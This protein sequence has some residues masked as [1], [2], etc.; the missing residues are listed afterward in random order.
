MNLDSKQIRVQVNTDK[1]TS[2][3]DVLTGRTPAMWRGNDIDV[4][5]GLFRNGALITDIDA[6]DSITVSIRAASKT[7]AILATKTIAYADINRACSASQWTAGTAQHAVASFLNTE[8]RFTLTAD[9]TSFWMVVTALTG[10]GKELTL[11]GTVLSVWQDGAG[12]D[13]TSPVVGANLIPG[14]AVY[15]GGGT[16]TFSGATVGK[17]YRWTKGVNDTNIVDTPN[18]YTI[19]NTIF[20]ALNTSFTLNGTPGAAVTAELRWPD[21][22][23][24]D[25]SD[26]RY[27]LA[28]DEAGLTALI[29]AAQADATQALADAVEARTEYFEAA[30]QAAMLLLAADKGDFA[31]RT[32]QNRFWLLSTSDPTVLANWKQLPIGMDWQGAWSSVTTYAV[33]DAVSKSGSSYISIQG[34]NLNHDPA[35]P[36]TIGVWWDVLAAGSTVQLAVAPDAVPTEIIA[37]AASAIG[38]HA[39]AARED[40]EHKA[41][42]ATQ[43]VT[44]LHAF[45]D[46]L[47]FDRTLGPYA[48]AFNAAVS[49]VY[50][51][52]DRIVVTGAFTRYGNCPAP[53]IMILDLHGFP[54]P[55]FAPGA[56]F[57]SGNTITFIAKASDG[58]YIL[59]NNAKT[60]YQAAGLA[61]IHKLDVTGT[62]DGAFTSPATMAVSGTDEL[63][64]IAT[65]TGKIW[66]VTWH[67][68]RVMDLTG[69]TT[70]TGTSDDNC[71][72]LT[73]KPGTA[74]AMLATRAATTFNGFA[75]PGALTLL[76]NTLARNGDWVTGASAGG[77][78]GA[79]VILWSPTGDFVIAGN[80]GAAGI[81]T[82]A[83][84]GGAANKHKGLWK[85]G[86][87]G[88]E[89][90][91]WTSTIVMTG[92]TANPQPMAIDSQNRVYF[93]GN[94]T[95]IDGTA[96]TANR[97]YRLN[98]DG[99]YDRQFAGFNGTVLRMSLVDDEHLVV[100]GSF[101]QY[102]QAEVG[103]M[104]F[105][106]S[107]GNL[108]P[109]LREDSTG[110]QA[111]SITGAGTQRITPKHQGILSLKVTVTDT[112]GGGG[113]TGTLILPAAGA[114]EGDRVRALFT[115]PA[116]TDPDI[117]IK[118]PDAAGSEVLGFNSKI[119]VSQ[120]E[121]DIVFKSG[122]WVAETPRWTLADGTPALNSYTR[123]TVTYAATVN[124][125]LDQ[126]AYQQITATGALTLG[127]LS[128]SRAGSGVAKTVTVLVTA[129]G[130]DRVIAFASGVK[131]IGDTLPS[132]KTAAVCLVST[133]SNE[134]DTLA[135][136]AQLD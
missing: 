57:A 10:T 84:E 112:Y 91:A 80:G 15:S 22:Y 7:G 11:G 106:D 31:K 97:L 100:C 81:G 75:V 58:D 94:V 102:G 35:D 85:I 69:T 12:S 98:A 23:T 66:C 89:D 30:S 127:T 126:Q 118:S 16:Y 67:S 111:I 17:V 4:Q 78:T 73:T 70:A 54:M 65:T 26:A 21:Y 79:N 71:H 83:W 38:V 20:T 56:G 74:L 64:S 29:S 88:N 113:F 50:L 28:F 133:G 101:T 72:W 99:S 41:L 122:V 59:G 120:M 103:G 8:T 136:Y 119:H 5:I 114:T 3:L 107:A 14:G 60:N 44:G 117:S 34:T 77:D 121:V 68:V 123:G 42:V 48:G 47:R 25:E 1:L 6:L 115:L 2:F 46:K 124:V 87:D 52:T 129:S 95:S 108:I 116:S 51:D 19:T 61:W 92:S 27:E 49:G 86:S 135:A 93:V 130:G 63:L 104:V 134:S 76:D 125:D 37:R 105:I 9:P 131:G 24:A 96:V 32:D 128:G 40:H 90:A 62:P 55:D 45:A 132:G 36:T 43:T 18:T 33:D 39:R 53:G 82:Y 13:E 110:Y 109:S